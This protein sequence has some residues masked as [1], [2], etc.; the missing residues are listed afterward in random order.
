[1]NE[2]HD[3]LRAAANG[4]LLT[5]RQLLQRGVDLDATN[6]F[7]R[8][9][10]HLAVIRNRPDVVRLLLAH[11]ADPNGQDDSGRTAL[12]WAAASGYG[13]MVEL[14]IAHGASIWVADRNGRTPADEALDYVDSHLAPDRPRPECPAP[15]RKWLSRAARA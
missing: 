3:L 9:A 7:D 15:P 8:S 1:M 6:A 5:V 10:L 13:D 14:L 12:H 4:D 2:E 11:G